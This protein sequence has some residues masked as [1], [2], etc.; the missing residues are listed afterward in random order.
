MEQEDMTMTGAGNPIDLA[1]D[2]LDP[3]EVETVLNSYFGSS[4]GDARGLRLPSDNPRIL[5]E[6]DRTTNA[7][8]FRPGPAFDPTEV[9]AIRRQISASL[10]EKQGLRIVAEVGFSTSP[11]EGS[12]EPVDGSWLLQPAPP[13]APR[14]SDSAGGGNPFIVYLRI[15][16]SDDFM[17][18]QRRR[19]QAFARWLEVMNA[20][21]VGGLSGA[22]RFTTK[23]WVREDVSGKSAAVWAQDWYSIPGFTAFPS[24]LPQALTPVA[25]V[26]D[27]EYYGLGGAPSNWSL[28]VPAGFAA[29][30]GRVDRLDP[31]DRA[32]LMNSARWR[33]TS[34]DLWYFSFASWFIAQVAA[35]E[36]LLPTTVR[37]KCPSCGRE[38][39]PG[40]TR[41]FKDFLERFATGPGFRTELDR[42]YSVRSKLVHGVGQLVSDAVFGMM[43]PAG[44]WERTEL[45]QLRRLV[46]ASTVGWLRDKV[47]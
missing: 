39:G 21:L 40:P 19:A 18:L 12:F 13:E 31:A 15:P 32:R 3:P 36:A 9:D 11:V 2:G 7:L 16:A 6:R 41:L 47:P 33:M 26:P 25:S 35:I 27:A 37:A 43:D 45:D 14:P 8:T 28:R 5:V 34:N 29:D 10:R 42:M 22:P 46:A 30:L 44:M 20:L 1:I 38:N 24:E 23:H 4:G 17:V